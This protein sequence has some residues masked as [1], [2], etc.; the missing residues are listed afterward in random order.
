[1]D[2]TVKE[3]IAATGAGVLNGD[4]E[5][6]ERFEISTD[7][8]TIDGRSVY[9]PLR[10]ENFDGENFIDNA[11]E[12]GAKG[13][14][15]SNFNRRGKGAEL[16]FAVEDTK[17]AYLKIAEYAREK[18]SPTTVMITG[19]SGKTTVKDMLARVLAEKYK[20][21]KT[22]KNFNNEIGL[23]KTV[24]SMPEDTRFLVTE[25]GMRGFG[26]IELIAKHVKPDIGVI[27][28]IGT[29]HIGRLGS[30]ENIAKAKCEILRHLNPEGVFIAPEDENIKKYNDFSGKTI[31]VKFDEA[32]I[33]ETGESGSLFEYRGEKYFVPKEGEHNVQNACLVVEVAKYAGLSADEI[34]AGLRAFESGENR[35]QAEK[36][37][38]FN[39]INDCYNANPDSMKAAAKTFL[40][41]YKSPK[42][43]ILGDMGELGKD[44]VRY[45]RE[46]GEFIGGFEFD[47]LLT[48]G[49]LAQNIL[50]EHNKH[51]H[52]ATKA[53]LVK[54]LKENFKTPTNVLIKASRSM[55]FEEISEA[56]RG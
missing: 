15:T 23:C 12:K 44:E 22:Q 53:E 11:L 30:V 26:E 6:G 51:K 3:L 36:I 38:N 43:L 39:V 33:S 35:W 7:T 19:S 41:T 56:L 52:F 49:E 55:K 28:N 46:T 48:C 14:F 47:A 27:T 45:H 29:A 21:H 25:G 31:Y 10:G 1:M 54:Y 24:L 13:Y 40:E 4:V 16:I 32:R 50:P 9:L 42:V 18:V 34:R 5:S 37:G 8:R 20:T 2:F 17:A